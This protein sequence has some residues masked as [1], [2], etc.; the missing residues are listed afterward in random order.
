MTRVLCT[1][2][3]ESRPK[4]GSSS[5]V[6]NFALSEVHLEQGRLE[7]YIGL[8]R[9]ETKMPGGRKPL[10]C[11]SGRTALNRKIR[12]FSKPPKNSGRALRKGGNYCTHPLSPPRNPEAFPTTCRT[13]PFAST[14]PTP[15]KAR[16]GPALRRWNLHL[17]FPPKTRGN[18]W[19]PNA[20]RRRFGAR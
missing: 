1:I 2:P 13:P 17:R 20:R 7:R 14:P 4:V 15:S 12:F 11:A 16:P 5:S 9:R 10:R 6:S 18:R 19:R 8:L 3:C